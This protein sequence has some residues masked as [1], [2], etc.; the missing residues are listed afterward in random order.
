MSKLKINKNIGKKFALCTLIS[1]V[2]GFSLIGCGKEPNFLKGT[3]LEE[4]VVVTFEDGT[5]EVAE[6]IRFCEECD[7]KHMLY[8]ELI[9]K[10]YF[11]DDECVEKIKGT[12]G[13]NHYISKYSISSVEGISKYLTEEEV[14]KVGA[15]GLKNDDIIEIIV[16]IYSTA[17]EK[18]ET[19]KALVK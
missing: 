18:T 12:F 11:T 17:Q 10:E 2:S 5:K 13:T 16:R 19:T 1:S 6:R 8:Q 15:D 4:A 7:E 14:E 9:S 3:V